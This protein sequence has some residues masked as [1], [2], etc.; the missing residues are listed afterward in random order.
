MRLAGIEGVI[1]ETKEKALEVFEALML[2]NR[3][4][5][6]II[7]E[8]ILA[9][10]EAEIMKLKLERDYPLIITIPDRDGEQREDYIA[11]YIRESVGIK[12]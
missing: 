9:I 6:V 11:K 5:I 8:K 1:V 2:D 3:I 4:G 10:A 12:I 7:T